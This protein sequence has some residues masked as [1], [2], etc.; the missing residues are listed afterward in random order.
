MSS[1]STALIDALNYEINELSPI[2]HY[3]E[4]MSVIKQELLCGNYRNISLWSSILKFF[5]VSQ[6]KDT[7]AEQIKS[8]LQSV[9]EHCEEGIIKDDSNSMALRAYIYL[10]EGEALF[11]TINLLEHAMKLGNS[12]AMT[13]RADIHQSGLEGDIDYP[14]AIKLYEQAIEKDEPFAMFRRARLY[15]NGQPDTIDYPAAIALYDKAINKHNHALSMYHRACIYLSEKGEDGIVNYPAAIK[16]LDRAVAL[17]EPLAMHLRAN[18]HQR[19]EGDSINISAANELYMKAAFLGHAESIYLAAMILLSNNTIPGTPE[20]IDEFLE[21]ASALNHPNAM[22]YLANRYLKRDPL[23]PEL[24]RKAI[25]LYRQAAEFGHEKANNDL[26]EQQC[27]YGDYHNSMLKK[28][29]AKVIELMQ[30]EPHVFDEFIAFD[31]NAFIDNPQK[32]NEQAM[33]V[34]ELFVKTKPTELSNNK[35]R[36]QML[37]DLAKMEQEKSLSFLDLRTTLLPSLNFS[38]LEIEI[39]SVAIITNMITDTWTQMEQSEARNYAP[40]ATRLLAELFWKN[41]AGLQE[42]YSN[43]SFVKVATTIVRQAKGMEP[44]L[45]SPVSADLGDL[46]RMAIDFVI[47]PPP[48]S[49]PASEKIENS[50]PSRDLRFFPSNAATSQQVT[51]DKSSSLTN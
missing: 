29:H 13:I 9:I 40:E 23:T 47:N 36:L 42:H 2:S 45:V 34:I 20:A 4:Q 44:M 6:W 49:N 7:G 48:D 22:H 30:T 26:Q 39:E 12:F 28:E 31:W 15:E 1:S 19:G 21:K 17:N 11:R 35:N 25:R 14:A 5:R 16:F 51:D 8:I 3:T 10:D 43:A 46:A 18:L 33:E 32:N 50:V 37:V 41:L 38:M 27:I 24:K